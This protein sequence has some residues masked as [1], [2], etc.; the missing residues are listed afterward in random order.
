M[1][2]IEILIVRNGGL[3]ALKRG[4]SVVVKNGERMDL[5]IEYH[6]YGPNGG[7]VVQVSQ[8]RAENGGVIRSPEMRFEICRD[9]VWIPSYL[10]D[11]AAA[12]PDVHVF[13]VGRGN[14]LLGIN[15]ELKRELA[16]FAAI[17]DVKL[18]DQG[19]LEA[20]V[21]SRYYPLFEEPSFAV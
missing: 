11:D 9:G 21:E 17:W 15:V 20:E 18:L 6:G 2:T 19:Y 5:E 16:M 13:T 8:Y 4:E 3:E 7:D 14:N 1:K 12:A 10:R